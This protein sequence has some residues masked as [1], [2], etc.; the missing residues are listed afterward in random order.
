MTI[1]Y[2]EC[3]R[4]AMKR[5]HIPFQHEESFYPTNPRYLLSQQISPARIPPSSSTIFPSK[6]MAT[7]RPSSQICRISNSITTLFPLSNASSSSIATNWSSNP[8]SHAF[9]L[10]PAD[11]ASPTAFLFQDRNRIHVYLLSYY[12]KQSA[13]GQDDAG[14]RDN[15]TKCTWYEVAKWDV[16]AE[17]AEASWGLCHSERNDL[18]EIK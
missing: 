18:E 14:T 7:P 16:R 15:E 1:S 5:L 10:P 9:D 2:A 6:R 4:S 17:A 13:M 12:A 8:L 3:L 11:A